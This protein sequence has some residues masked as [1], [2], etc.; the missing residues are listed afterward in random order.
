MLQKL[1]IGTSIQAVTAALGALRGSNGPKSEK[2]NVILLHSMDFLGTLHPHLV[3]VKLTRATSVL[4][5]LQEASRAL[6]RK[7]NI[8]DRSS[9]YRVFPQV[10]LSDS[11]QSDHSGQDSVP[12]TMT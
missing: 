5:W 1:S 4:R 12:V 11:C 9:A 7:E 8:L 3:N 2:K 10:S 6:I